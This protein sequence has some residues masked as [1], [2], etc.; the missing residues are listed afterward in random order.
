MCGRYTLRT[1][2][3]DLA[4]V[5]PGLVAD[6][7]LGPRYNIAPTQDA[8]VVPNDG[9][10]RV[11]LFRWGLVPPWAK[12][13][14]IGSRMINAR[15]ET[16]AEKPSFRRALARRRCLVLAD[17]FYEWGKGADGKTKTPV[18]FSLAT[19]GPFAM[20]GLWE[21]WQ[22][23]GEPSAEPL[24]T[25]TIVTG[26]PNA[27]VAEVH[28]RMPVVLRPG[29]VEAWVAPEARRPDDLA[30][31]LAHPFPAEAMTA[32]TVSRRVNSPGTEGPECLEPT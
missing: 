13:H 17:G 27:L 10:R 3:E 19:G 18:W 32:R 5:L 31:I 28:A 11:R 12:D 23:P 25:F 20:A 21:R 24:H 9:S 15:A 22:D 16:L 8:A 29:D 7:E 26:P 6:V 4:T 1:S 2:A 30:P 14:A